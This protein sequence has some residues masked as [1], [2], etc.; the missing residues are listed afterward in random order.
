MR[1]HDVV[2][3]Q[4]KD[5][6]RAPYDLL[7][8][9]D[10]SREMIE[11]YL[12]KGVCYVAKKASE[13]V[14][15][16][17]LTERDARVIEIMNIAVKASEQGQGLGRTLLDY[18]EKMSRDAGYGRLVIG[19]GNS[20]IAQLIL[21]QKAGFEITDIQKDFFV[22]QYKEPIIE[23]GIHCKHKIVLEKRIQN[24]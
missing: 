16:V 13:M 15:V 1:G 20:S 9:A 17:V 14:G 12:S 22:T 18:C 7:L 8:M 19:T 11:S 5:L 4:L 6:S 3:E 10:P 23:N 21:Y 24:K 2:I